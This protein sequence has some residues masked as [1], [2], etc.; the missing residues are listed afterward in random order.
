[1]SIFAKIFSKGGTAVG[2]LDIGASTT[3]IIQLAASGNN[4]QLV[5]VGLCPTPSMAIKDGVIVEP[6]QVSESIK[7]LLASQG[8]AVKRVVSAVTGQSVVIRPIVMPAMTEKELQSAI[9]FGAEQYLPYPVSDAQITGHILQK[10]IPGDEKNM[11][12]LLMG[13]PKEMVRSAEGVISQAGLQSEAIELEPLALLRTL[14]F[15]FGSQAMQQTVAL[16]NLG[17][18]SSSINIYK[19]GVPKHNRTIS[20]AGNSFTKVIGQSLNLSFDEAEKL[21]KEKGVIRL[22]TDTT[23]YPPQTMRIFSVI[24]SVLTELVTEIQ[25]SFDYYRSRYRGESVD[26]I[27]LSGGTAKF[28]NIDKYLAGELGITVELVNPFQKISPAGVPGFSPDELT[29][30]GSMLL[31]VLGLAAR[32]L[33]EQVLK[34]A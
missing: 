25:R 31:V 32:N 10:P 21:K 34:Q 8:I 33:P 4:V 23:Q 16:I 9:K 12:V 14:N 1:M 18:S 27:I 3:K 29:E 20:V 22:E 26:L 2:G 24:T 7:Q 13:A 5:K 17:A 19:G 28:K 30:L 6:A 11:E 15:I